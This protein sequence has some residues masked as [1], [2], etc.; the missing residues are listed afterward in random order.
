MYQ[1]F[2]RILDFKSSGLCVFNGHDPPPAVTGVVELC[3]KGVP[4]LTGQAAKA[5]R[6]GLG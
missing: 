4:R 1:I 3:T 2:Q 5:G 6:N